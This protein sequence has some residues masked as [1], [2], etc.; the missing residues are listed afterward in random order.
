VAVLGIDLRKTSYSVAGAVA[1]AMVVLPRR[2][3]R[4]LPALLDKLPACVVEMEACRGVHHLGHAAE[5]L[6]QRVRLMPPDSVRPYVNA[7][8]NDDRDAEAIANRGSHRRLRRRGCP[9]KVLSWGQRAT[10]YQAG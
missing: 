8:T 1:G 9:H 5:A 2:V 3:A 7:K 4:A 6:G 10:H